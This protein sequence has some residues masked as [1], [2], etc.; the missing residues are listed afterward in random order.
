VRSQ[1]SRAQ[2]QL[3]HSRHPRKSRPAPAW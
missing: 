2:S 3:Y 1:A